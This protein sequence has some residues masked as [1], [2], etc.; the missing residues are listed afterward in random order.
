MTVVVSKRQWAIAP[1]TEASVRR[2]RTSALMGCE[3]LRRMSPE[4]LVAGRDDSDTESEPPGCRTPRAGASGRRR[5]PP[6]HRRP[7]VRS[8][9]RPVALA[10]AQSLARC[11]S[12][13]VTA[14]VVARVATLRRMS[15]P[16]VSRL[17]RFAKRV[18]RPITSPIDGRVAD[19]N[20]R[21]DATK[22]TAAQQGAILRERIDQLT[23]TIDAH[24]ELM[25]Y[26]GTE[27]RR[28]EETFQW[29]QDQLEELVRSLHEK[30][31]EEYFRERLARTCSLEQL[32]APLAQILN[33][34]VSHRG[35]AAQAELWFN[36]PITV[37]FSAGAA[38]LSQ[39]NERIVE[40]PFA[41]AGLA[42]IAP[43]AAILDIG[44]AESTF[45]LSAA[46]LGYRVTAIDPR[47]LPYSHPNLESL[48]TRFEDWEGQPGSF[49][50]AFLISAIEHVGLSAYGDEA[51]GS[52]DPGAG[53]DRDLL[54]RVR[55]FLA[56]GG[57]LVLTAPYG[58]RAVND[59]ERT[60][61]DEAVAQLLD[62]WNVIDRRVVL[63]RDNLRW[64]AQADHESGQSGVV[65][66]LA[67]P[68]RV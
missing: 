35:F 14:P 54:N 13:G 33:Y 6:P 26:V 10:V 39:V 45:P 46:A 68:V 31:L 40:V 34:A 30:S 9:A 60:Y 47:P 59:F 43:P 41:M 48:A 44:S 22:T 20:R 63:R 29:R 65:M 27:L 52:R 11:G 32:D 62:G 66:L 56:P 55:G 67:T 50:G 2:S 23:G 7:P 8:R 49:S 15:V 38:R 24:G 51:Y 61:D 25:S 36:P 53:A 16:R 37:E 64:V 3:R 1:V 19:I 42:R 28:L 21:V 17:K 57:L 4:A 58:S 5:R 18:A 12:D